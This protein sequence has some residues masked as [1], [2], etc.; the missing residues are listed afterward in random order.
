MKKYRKTDRIRC[1]FMHSSVC[2]S[3]YY[4]NFVKLDARHCYNVV[5]F[6]SVHVDLGDP[7]PVFC[8]FVTLLQHD[9]QL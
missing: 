9:C 6:A 8:D 7:V 2:V 4:A 3:A 5:L 1:L